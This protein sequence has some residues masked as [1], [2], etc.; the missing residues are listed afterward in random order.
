V[1]IELPLGKMV[2]RHLDAIHMSYDEIPPATQAG[3]GARDLEPFDV[4]AHGSDHAWIV[5]VG[6][7]SEHTREDLREWEDIF[8]PGFTALL[9]TQPEEERLEFRTLDGKRIRLEDMR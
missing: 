2:R 9:A 7:V 5:F 4:I 8:G 1:P 3:F 6:D